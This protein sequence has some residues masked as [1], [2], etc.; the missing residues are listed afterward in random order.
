MLLYEKGC[1]I[2][3]IVG[4]LCYWIILV[5]KNSWLFQIDPHEYPGLEDNRGRI[6]K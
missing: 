1:I 3:G 4:K 6:M 2:C 5:A